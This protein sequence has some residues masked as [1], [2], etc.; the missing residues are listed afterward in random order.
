MKDCVDFIRNT[1]RPPKGLNAEYCAVLQKELYDKNNCVLICKAMG[2]R[3]PQT[4]PC[5]ADKIGLF[6]MGFDRGD[7]KEN[8]RMQVLH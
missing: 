5:N 4:I 6:Y 8:Y 3:E 7:W 1:P 2:N